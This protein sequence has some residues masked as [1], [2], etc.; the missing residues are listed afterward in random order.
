MPLTQDRM[1]SLI[2]AAHAY[3]DGLHQ[4][5]HM[6]AR[7]RANPDAGSDVTLRYQ[8]LI[9]TL[10]SDHYGR[11]A[12]ESSHF[13]RNASRNIKE[14]QRQRTM[15][16]QSAPKPDWRAAR[17][18]EIDRNRPSKEEIEAEI[19]AFLADPDAYEHQENEKRAQ[20]QAAPSP[21]EAA[22]LR[23]D[24]IEPMPIPG[25][26]GGDPFAR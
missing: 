6:L 7:L 4:I 9:R 21:D 20:A 16:Q 26:K 10:D 14:A 25:T 24:G 1:L 22:I 5:G 19:A 13:A 8:A 3:R 12:D 23:R 15:R 17:Q 11:L 18:A 2:N